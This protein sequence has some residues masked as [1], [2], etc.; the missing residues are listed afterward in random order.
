[1]TF[2]CDL[3]NAGGDKEQAYREGWGIVLSLKVLLEDISIRDCVVILR[4]DCASAL[5]ALE[6]GSRRSTQL[7]AAF[8]E[9]HRECI[10]RGIF[11]RFLHVS[12]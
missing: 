4:N 2:L 6:K 7:Q 5:A 9:L 10:A 11:P 12:G 1:M 3:S 8:V